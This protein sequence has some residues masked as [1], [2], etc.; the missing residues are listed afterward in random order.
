MAP[1]AA[2]CEYFPSPFHFTT[3]RLS[4]AFNFLEVVREVAQPLVLMKNRHY[5]SLPYFMH[6]VLLV[7]FRFVLGGERFWIGASIIN[8]LYCTKYSIGSV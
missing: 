8:G 3:Q 2:S 1:N 6:V 7:L 5:A 4:A